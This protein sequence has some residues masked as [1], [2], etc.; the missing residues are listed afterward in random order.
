MC[1]RNLIPQ[2]ATLTLAQLDN[3][4]ISGEYICVKQIHLRQHPTIELPGICLC[5]MKSVC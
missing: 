1:S 2:L 5:L 4:I 3:R